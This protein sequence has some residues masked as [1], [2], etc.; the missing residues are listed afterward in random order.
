MKVRPVTRHNAF[1]R[2]VQLLD[3]LL[4]ERSF[5]SNQQLSDDEEEQYAEALDECRSRMPTSQVEQLARIIAR[6]KRA[7]AK[8]GDV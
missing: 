7:Y 4:L 3:E 6:K 2:Y 1:K 8:I 5:S